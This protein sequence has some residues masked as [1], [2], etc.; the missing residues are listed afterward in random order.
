MLN[1]IPRTKG[2]V[3]DGIIP[4]WHFSRRRHSQLAEKKTYSLLHLYADSV[5]TN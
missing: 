4:S 1:S 3:L 2:M 5:P